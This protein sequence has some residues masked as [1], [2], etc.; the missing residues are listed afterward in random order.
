LLNLSSSNLLA[1]K[2]KKKIYRSVYGDKLL[3][4]TAFFFL[5]QLKYNKF[6][7]KRED[8]KESIEY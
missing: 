5:D 4:E 7:P 8:K 2:K 6:H 3:S 1:T